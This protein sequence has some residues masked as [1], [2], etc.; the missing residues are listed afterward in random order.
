MLLSQIEFVFHENFLLKESLEQIMK[1]MSKAQLGDILVQYAYNFNILK[2]PPN[3]K[4]EIFKKL[5]EIFQDKSNEIV[6]SMEMSSLAHLSIVC[7]QQLLSLDIIGQ[8]KEKS[9][10]ILKQKEDRELE[11]HDVDP[12]C[13]LIGSLHV[14]GSLTP[15]LLGVMVE[16]FSKSLQSRYLSIEQ[17]SKLYISLSRVQ[18]IYVDSSESA[19]F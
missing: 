18:K 7:V 9:L 17:Y 19:A 11:E 15:Q 3:P 14:S 12:I 2:Y 5:D 4:L 8:I 13:L 1:S 10:E 6:E 16:R